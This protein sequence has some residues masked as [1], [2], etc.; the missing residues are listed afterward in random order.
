MGAD[1]MSPLTIT[2]D[3]RHPLARLS[4]SPNAD[5]TTFGNAGS[6]PA[7]QAEQVWRNVLS[8]LVGF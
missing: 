8:T 4:K 2:S 5:R 3:S 1:V 7:H 6:I